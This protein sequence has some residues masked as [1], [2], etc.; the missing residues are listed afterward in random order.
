MMDKPFTV[1][2]LSP[3]DWPDIGRKFRDLT[4]EQ[5]LTYSIA[6]A[7]RIRARPEFLSIVDATGKVVAAAAARVRKIPGIGRGIVWIPSGPLIRPTDCGEPP[8]ER[9]GGI[10]DALQD[11]YVHKAGHILRIR[12]PII[13]QIEQTDVFERH[14][15][16]P[17]MNAAAYQTVLVDLTKSEDALWKSL[18]GKWR[19]PL[20]NAMKA[21]IK[22]DH[23][24]FT[25]SH[26]RFFPLYNQVQQAKGFEP[27]IGPEF[28]KDLTGPDFEH[29]TLIAH[30]DGSNI[31]TMTIGRSGK[32]AVYLFGATPDEGRKLN[33]GHL[34][35]WHAILWAAEQGC[36]WFDLGGISTKDNPD[37]A[38]FKL[39]TG[40]EEIAALGPYEARAQGLIPS[41][42]LVAEQ[43]HKKLEHFTFIREHIRL[44]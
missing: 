40:G 19:N 27:D 24:S 30:K 13:S 44:L 29:D 37:V 18:H 17:T 10:L 41:S 12:L 22:I 28:Y 11:Y 43:I 42:I 9:L 23:L 20:R 34:L 39:R 6:A 1:R 33:A 3:A 4:Y 8:A 25:E 2:P 7:G 31:G 14:G 16:S 32:S 5:S 26:D 36:D 38:R 35:M 15:L 21:G